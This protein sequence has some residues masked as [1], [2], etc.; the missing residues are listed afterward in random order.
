MKTTKTQSEIKILNISIQL[1]F[2]PYFASSNPYSFPAVSPSPSPS[3]PFLPKQPFLNTFNYSFI[4]FSQT[5]N[6]KTKYTIYSTPGVGNWCQMISGTFRSCFR[7]RK[8]YKNNKV[9]INLY[10]CRYC[11]CCGLHR[12]SF[13]LNSRS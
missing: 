5:I 10:L 3:P 7:I 6:K 4:L 13:T 8:P 1:R 12:L 11:F 9:L 2:T